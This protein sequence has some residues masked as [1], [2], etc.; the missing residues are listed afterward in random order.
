MPKVDFSLYA[1]REQ[2]YIKHCLLEE[3]L[4][5]WGW[6]IGSQWDALVYVDGFA[7]PWNVRSPDFADSSFGIAVGALSRVAS[8]LQDSRQRKVAVR[9]VCVEQDSDAFTKLEAFAKTSSRSGFTVEALNGE[10]HAQVPQICRIVERAGNSAFKF[11]FL[12][13]K[14]WSLN[15]TQLLPLIKGRSCEVVVN[16]MTRHIIRF[17]D[18]EDRTRS[19]SDLLG[20]SDAVESI[21]KLSSEERP[22]ALVREYCKSLHTLAGYE[23]VSSAAIFDPDKDEIRYFLVY[24]TNHHRGIEVFKAA[25]STAA[26][27]QDAIRHQAAMK[28]AGGQGDMFSGLFG[29]GV[30][31]SNFAFKQWEKYCAKARRKIL[32][33]L[34]ASPDGVQFKTLFCDAMAFPLV[35]PRE[36]HGWLEE[37]KQQR[38]IDYVL[39]QKDGENRKKPSAD[40]EDR[41]LVLQHDQLKA[42]LTSP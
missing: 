1:G 22:D 9:C 15:M 32:E 33:R 36:L 16:L 28:K 40:R 42:L 21:R 12:D 13:P 10:F 31:A 17:L 27:L 3:Y 14:G 20:R 19:I 24:G 25:E 38:W 35:T 41:V 8:G 30:P 11:V 23:Y 26:K 4:P 37:W 34:A 5:E 2:A 39:K 6:K 7:G 18:E 29:E